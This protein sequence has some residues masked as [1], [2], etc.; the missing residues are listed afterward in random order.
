MPRAPARA[1]P[2]TAPPLHKPPLPRWTPSLLA[3]SRVRATTHA[4]GLR[5]PLRASS[6]LR[7]AARLRTPPTASARPAASAGLLPAP[8]ATDVRL[9]QPSKMEASRHRP[10]PEHSLLDHL[11]SPDPSLDFASPP[12]AGLR[13]GRS[14]SFPAAA[15]PRT[16]QLRPSLPDLLLSAPHR[17][18]PQPL[19][20]VPLRGLPSHDPTAA[21]PPE[22]P[23]SPSPDYAATVT[24]RTH[25]SHPSLDPAAPEPHLAGPRR[26]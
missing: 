13:R 16:T 26:T 18:P 6:A 8:H 17:T 9:M 20:S 22:P 14:S 21:G 5:R 11:S 25:R 12:L 15:S 7:P 23:P 2:A 3:S 10:C 19:L 1:S 24:H 4:A